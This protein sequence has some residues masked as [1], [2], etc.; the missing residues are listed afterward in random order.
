MLKNVNFYPYQLRVLSETE[1]R[2]NIAFYLDCG[3]GKTYLS[4]ESMLRFNTSYNLCIVQKSKVKDWCDVFKEQGLNVIDFTKKNAII[5][6]GVIVINYEL[7]WRREVLSELKDFTL[8]L[9]ESSKI[10][11]EKTKQTKFIMNLRPSH[12]VLA[13]GT[14]CSGKY[15]NLYTQLKLLGYRDTKTRYYDNFVNYELKERPHP[16]K[17]NATIKYMDIYGYKNVERLKQTLRDYGAVFMLADDYLDLPDKI[18]QTV[19]VES[20]SIYKKFRKEHLV[21][22][23]DVTFAGD[24]PLKK[25][26]YERQLCGAWNDNKI[27]AV[28][29]IIDSTN[30]R[31]VIFYNFE[32]DYEVLKEIVKSKDKHLSYVNGHGTELSNYDNY[33]D[34]VILIQY[35]SGAYGLNL[36]K[37]NKMILFE[38]PISCEYYTQALARTHRLGQKRTC[39]YWELRG[40]EIETKIYDVIKQG[41]DYTLELYKETV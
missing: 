28:S 25:L 13:S 33:D 10:Q 23:G 9:D 35:Q 4:V 39:V 36:Q 41:R 27:S 11:H 38:P 5:D 17:P 2:K 6:K 22:A 29:D 8:I 30:D 15:E 20:S 40:G 14:P 34:T 31:L 12:V 24:T 32:K 16:S 3:M 19:N 18:Y 21:I 7:C 1:K 26:L 37:C